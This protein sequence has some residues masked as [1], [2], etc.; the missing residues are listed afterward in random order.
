MKMINVLI[1]SLITS[2]L[3]S[4]VVYADL[5]EDSFKEIEDGYV[6]IHNAEQAGGNVTVVIMMLNQALDIASRGNADNLIEAM[7]LAKEAKS[8]AILIEQTSKT[9]QII[10]YFKLLVFLFICFMAMILIKKY[11]DLIYYS[12]WAK[13]RG[14]WRI[15]KI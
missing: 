1:L 9:E 2:A 8:L 7:T 15:E 10:V 13:I 5:T 11:G 3:F 6:A 14:N 4:S 12:I